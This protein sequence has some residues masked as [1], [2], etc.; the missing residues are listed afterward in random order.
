MDCP[1]TNTTDK[2]ADWYSGYEPC[3][4]HYNSLETEI[5]WRS[6]TGICAVPS[7]A[8]EAIDWSVETRRIVVSDTRRDDFR[9]DLST[10][11]YFVLE[12]R[13]R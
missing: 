10:G 13:A 11:R 3:N 12:H 8:F 2:N 6:N 1:W 5:G 7:Y 4:N 9:E